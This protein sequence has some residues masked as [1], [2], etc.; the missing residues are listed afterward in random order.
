MSEIKKLQSEIQGLKDRNKNLEFKLNIAKLWMIREIKQSVKKISKKKIAN[1][2]C[3]SK[4][5]FARDNLDDIITEKIRAYFWD[6]I[7]MNVNSSA[8]D[9]IVSAE[10]AYYQLKQNPNFD[11]FGVISSYH[12]A[13][14]AIIEQLITKWYRKFAK[15]TGQIHLRKNDSLEKRFHSVVNKWYGLW[16]G[17]LYHI[18]NKLKNNE[19]LYDYAWNFKEYLDK[20]IDL[21]EALLNDNFLNI[22]KQIVNLEILWK[23]RHSWQISFIDTR[24]ARKLLIW[25]LKDKNSLIYMILKTQDMDY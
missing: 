15:K 21:K 24:K 6:F 13:L 8:I 19:E 20:Y 3:D 22:F 10:L 4:N 12:K 14:D 18:L 5:D 23:K 25:N 16:I 9:N 2:A 1:I 11:G 17:R 7:L